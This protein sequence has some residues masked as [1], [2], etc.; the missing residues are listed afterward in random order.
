MGVDLPGGL[1]DAHIALVLKLEVDFLVVGVL[2]GNN[3]LFVVSRDGIA[4]GEVPGAISIGFV[5][6]E[7]ALVV[8]AVGEEPLA[9]H[10]LVFGPLSHELSPR[11]GVG[12]SA[13]S[14]FLAEHPP[15]RITIL[16]G[17]D[18]GAL[19]ML[20]PVLPLPCLTNPLP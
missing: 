17:V 14:V 9:T 11:L 8:V 6:A 13:L 2:V 15:P 18:V 7:A 10:E 1:A 3:G 20:H 5:V 19:S 4:V 16:V 12:V